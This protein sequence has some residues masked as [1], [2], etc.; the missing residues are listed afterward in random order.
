MCYYSDLFGDVIVTV[1]DV[2]LWLDVVAK[3][4]GATNQR[5]NYYAINN[6]VVS[7]IKL[8]KLHNQFEKLINDQLAASEYDQIPLEAF[9]TI[10]KIAASELNHEPCPPYFHT[11]DNPHCEIY[12]KRCNHDKHAK[13]YAKRKKYKRTN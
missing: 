13:A 10:Y 3:M 11:C 12:I 8:S 6:D 9:R 4:Q 7:K 2:N 5:R 1:N